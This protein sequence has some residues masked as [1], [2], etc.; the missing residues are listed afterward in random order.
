MEKKSWGGVTKLQNMNT[1][2][3]VWTK[4][5]LDCYFYRFFANYGQY[6]AMKLK[7]TYDRVYPVVPQSANTFNGHC[8]LVLNTHGTLRPNWQGN[9]YSAEFGGTCHEYWAQVYKFHTNFKL[10]WCR[11]DYEP[12]W[13]WSLFDLDPIFGDHDQ[14]EMNFSESYRD[15]I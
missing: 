15:M 6:F 9:F 13:S 4:R 7:F 14:I 12:K 10:L 1:W 8:T 2:P 11:V 5:V 3:Q